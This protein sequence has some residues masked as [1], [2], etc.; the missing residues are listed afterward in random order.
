M[1]LVVAI[2]TLNERKEIMRQ[3]RRVTQDFVLIDIEST[4]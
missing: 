3:G 1:R 2:R 4:L